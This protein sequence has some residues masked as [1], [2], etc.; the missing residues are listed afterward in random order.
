M[1]R[2]TFLFLSLLVALSLLLGACQPATEAPEVEEPT[3]VEETEVVEETEEPTE[4]PEVGLEDLVA[5]AEESAAAAAAS[6]EAAAAA[7]AGVPEGAAAVADL[8]AG[9]ELVEYPEVGDID[10]IAELVEP[11]GDLVSFPHR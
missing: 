8:V 4:E 2:Y 11:E 7:A 10:D 6:A 5:Q 3:E 1:K 9:Y